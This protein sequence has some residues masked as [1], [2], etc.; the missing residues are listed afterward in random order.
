MI[1]RRE[2]E[3]VREGTIGYRFS[4]AAQPLFVVYP[5]R[6]IRQLRLSNTS[7]NSLLFIL[8]LQLPTSSLWTTANVRTK[9][10]SIIGELSVLRAWS[11]VSWFLFSTRSLHSR[12]RSDLFSK[13]QCPNAVLIPNY[14]KLRGR[15]RLQPC[16]ERLVTASISVGLRTQCNH[17]LKI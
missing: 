14:A 4:K 8:S 5:T 3:S 16:L 10:R 7:H 1:R 15:R 12:L 9:R 13:A 2:Q 17:P 11:M 6:F